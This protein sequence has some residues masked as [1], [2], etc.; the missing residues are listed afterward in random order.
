[1]TGVEFVNFKALRDFKLELG[2][3]NVLVGPNNCGKSTIISA[4]RAL[5][6][7][8]RKASSKSATI[9]EGPRGR[10]LGHILQAD[11]LPLSLENVH[12]DYKGNDSSIT[13]RLSN[14][15][16]MMLWFPEGRATVLIPTAGQRQ[17]R[18]P[19]DFK[20]EFAVSLGVVPVLGP[21][22]HRE[23]LLTDDYV[24]RFIGTHR[25]SRLFR[26]YWRLYPEGFEDFANLVAQTWP[27]MTIARPEVIMGTPPILAMFS[28]EAGFPRELFWS[29]FGFQIWCQLLTHITRARSATGLIVDEP[30]VYLHPDVQRQLMGI[31]RDAGP[32]V[33]I[34][35]HSTEI[36]ADADVH[37]II[38]VDKAKQRGRRLR[39]VAEVQVVLEAIGSVHNVT[40]TKIARNR[41]V[42]FVEDDD[43]YKRLRRFAAR[44]GLRS[45]SSGMAVSSVP[46]GG[47][48]S[49]QQIKHMAGLLERTLSAKLSIAAVYDRDY[50]CSEEIAEAH[51]ELRRVITLAHFHGRKELENYMLVPTALNRIVSDHVGSPVDLSDVI[52]DIT[53]PR[54]AE[55]LGQYLAKKSEY[56]RR[57]KK[58]P[59]TANAEA[60]AWFEKKWATID[61]RIE[62]SCGKEVLSAIRAHCK[63]A[64]NI[65]L[66]DIRLIDSLRRDEI[67][68][69]LVELLRSLDGF[70]R[71]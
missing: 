15:N 24:R 21:V 55:W 29:G 32:S 14:G 43:D 1:V 17:L 69:D 42:L 37:E 53:E 34:A 59:A 10:T 5:D 7:G 56:L 62:I 49:W 70:A 18:S 20:R 19:S 23:E 52:H 27:S 51:D 45:F 57:T 41:R 61:G 12:T 31:L 44:L 63:T 36:I 40:L 68:T 35:T 8:I 3:I 48:S 16:S 50:W 9:V 60:Y 28:R 39:D 67:P 46:S 2:P 54:K 47:F 38:E 11:A 66:T 6:V 65:S 64:W 30:E 26:N 58:D 25:A 22:E 4:F 71:S 33:L 13:F